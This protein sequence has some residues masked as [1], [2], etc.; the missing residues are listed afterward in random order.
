M[1]ILKKI[2]SPFFVVV[3][4]VSIFSTVSYAEPFRLL[5]DGIATVDTSHTQISDDQDS[6]GVIFCTHHGSVELKVGSTF[7]NP[8]VV[9]FIKHT[10]DLTLIP[11]NELM[12]WKLDWSVYSPNGIKLAG[13]TRTDGAAGLAAGYTV[14]E[15][16]TS[17]QIAFGCDFRV[18]LTTTVHGVTDESEWVS[19]TLVRPEE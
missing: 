13:G 7:D 15:E 8:K 18:K 14:R 5:Q 6:R 4:L 3:I 19:V 12:Y 9:A 17:G 16:F 10:K 11:C 2:V 1:N